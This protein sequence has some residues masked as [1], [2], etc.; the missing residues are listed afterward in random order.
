[1]CIRD[2]ERQDLLTELMSHDQLMRVKGGKVAHSCRGLSVTVELIG[3]GTMEELEVF[4]SNAEKTD[5]KKGVT[6]SNIL[7]AVAYGL[8]AYS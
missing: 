2:R 8:H 7:R 4:G 3:A 1:M 5:S 6:R